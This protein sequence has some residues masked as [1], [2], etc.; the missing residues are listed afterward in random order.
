MN[1]AFK[2]LDPSS[3]KIYQAT[4]V[5]NFETDVCCVPLKVRNGYVIEHHGPVAPWVRGQHIDT[6]KNYFIKIEPI[7]W[8]G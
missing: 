5:Y 1:N 2:H 8:I 6:L 7:R 3:T 4:V